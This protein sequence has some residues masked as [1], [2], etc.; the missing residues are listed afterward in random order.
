MRLSTLATVHR[1]PGYAIRGPCLR[2]MHIFAFSC[3]TRYRIASAL[4]PC[5]ALV[6]ASIRHQVRGTTWLC[7]AFSSHRTSKLELTC[8]AH[9]PTHTHLR[10]CSPARHLGWSSLAGPDPAINH[11]VFIL[12]SEK[13]NGGQKEDIK[14]N[15]NNPIETPSTNTST[16]RLQTTV[17]VPPVHES[18]TTVVVCFFEPSW[19]HYCGG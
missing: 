16:N 7:L 4:Y 19:R 3:Q 14:D 17:S 1:S 12:V 5:I 10:V 6:G 18:T 15:N 8:L 11:N 2:E 9:D 13:E